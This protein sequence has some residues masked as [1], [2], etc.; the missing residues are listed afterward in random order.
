[1]AKSKLQPLADRVIVSASFEKKTLSG[2]II[3]DSA[4]KDRP[5]QGIVVAVGPGRMGN[6]NKRVPLEVK[7]GDMVL[8]SKYGPDEVKVEGQNF[9]VLR[10]DQILAV[11]K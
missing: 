1:M 9:F 3:P 2:I 6:D 11:I 4:S 8:F 5:V 10:E 7:V